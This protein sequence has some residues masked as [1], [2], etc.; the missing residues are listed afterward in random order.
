MGER[1]DI[2]YIGSSYPEYRDAQVSEATFFGIHG[3]VC[4]NEFE[5]DAAEA[6]L[7][8][9]ANET[10]FSFAKINLGDRTELVKNANIIRLSE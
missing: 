6:E 8:V 9:F 3:P 5:A 7:V 4:K 1:L 2:T 10:L